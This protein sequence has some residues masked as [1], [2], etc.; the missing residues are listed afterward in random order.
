LRYAVQN[1]GINVIPKFLFDEPWTW[2]FF[3]LTSYNQVMI[4]QLVFNQQVGGADGRRGGP[5]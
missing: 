1:S 5:I 4:F 3:V 2:T